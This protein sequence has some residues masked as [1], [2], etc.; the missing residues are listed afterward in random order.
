MQRCQSVSVVVPAFNE[1]Q[2]LAST[3]HQ[4][5]ADLERI[6][7]AFEVILA[8]NGSTDET[9]QIADEL[10]RTD[11]RVRA[12]HLDLPDYGRAMRQGFLDSAA[13][14]VLN[15]SVD[16]VDIGFLQTALSELDRADVVLGS[17]Y[18]AR[19]HDRRPLQ[20]RLGG[21]FLSNLV[22]VLFHLPVSDTH[23]LLAL[24]RDEVIALVEKC[25]FGNEVFDTELIVRAHR[26]GLAMCEIPVRVEEQ[27]PNRVGAL[28]RALRMLRQYAALRVVLWQEGG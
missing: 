17:K 7:V 28:R 20:R 3:V 15:F 6:G 12:I 27:R 21:I 25:R 2:L 11:H 8:Q 10:A 18:V 13:D 23:G 19:S 16:F 24:R 1:E 22:R 14:C 4:L 9:P 26:A 5:L